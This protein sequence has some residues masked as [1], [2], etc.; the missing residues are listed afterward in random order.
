MYQARI[1][2]F[3]LGGGGDC[4]DSLLDVII[5]KKSYLLP[6]N[7]FKKDIIKLFPTD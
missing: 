2:E 4:F 7:V 3:M 5:S 1:Q 6:K